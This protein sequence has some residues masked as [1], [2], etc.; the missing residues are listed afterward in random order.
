[1]TLR[2]TFPANFIIKARGKQTSA[3]GLKSNRQATG[4]YNGFLLFKRA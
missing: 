3:D 2:E 4:D 1:M